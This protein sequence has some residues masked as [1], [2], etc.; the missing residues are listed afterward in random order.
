MRIAI[1]TFLHES[2]GFSNDITDIEIMKTNMFQDKDEIIDLQRG[3]IVCGGSLGGYVDYAEA[4]GWDIVPTF[5]AAAYP[6]GPVTKDTYEYVKKKMLDNLRGEEVDAVLLHLHGAAVVEG[7]DDAEGD[8]LS[9]IRDLVGEDIP[10]M[11]ILDLHANVSDLMVDKS[12]AIYAYDTY[13][14]EDA[15][16]REE[17]V[18][19]LLEKVVAGEVKPTS[20]RGQPPILFPAMFTTTNDGPMKKLREKAVEWEQNEKVVNVSVFAGFYGSDK[21][22]AGPSIV[23]ITN[24]DPELAESVAKDM[25]DYM[26]ELKDDFFLPMTPIDETIETIRNTPGL[27]AVIDECDDPMGGGAS[28]GTFIL[29]KFL[30]SDIRPGGVSY[31]RDPEIVKAAKEAGVG[32]RVQGLLGGKVDDKHGEPVEIDATVVGLF[33]KKIPR[34]FYDPNTL[35]DIG[36]VAILDQDGIK[37]VVTE[38][39][40]NSEN[41]VIFQ[42]F[43][44]D[45][46]DMR[47]LILKGS[48]EAYKVAYGQYEVKPDAYITPESIGIT[49]PDVTK[50]GDFKKLRR[51]LI[52]F[53]ENVELRYK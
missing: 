37:I 29:Q 1:G 35:Q 2:H 44:V 9:A 47:F 27:W 18:C 45:I 20:Y 14:H 46:S 3:T 28:D 53:D 36:E 4:H 26:W 39:K 24:D 25:V 13:P 21:Y 49:N 43:D 51:P 23:V 38:L 31:I 33:N 50:I 12:N 15:H 7:Y 10:I 40:A 34:E 42:Y 6:A 30:E 48:G 16:E 11:T 5:V 22:E 8:L 52:P 41:I 32:G 19:E 17:E